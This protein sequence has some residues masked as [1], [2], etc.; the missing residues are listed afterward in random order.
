[1]YSALA[2]LW[3]CSRFTVDARARRDI[4]MAALVKNKKEREQK[5]RGSSSRSTDVGLT[6]SSAQGVSANT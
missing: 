5:E 6:G 3:F 1:M 2:R 4:A